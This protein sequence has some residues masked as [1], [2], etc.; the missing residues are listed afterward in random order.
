LLDLVQSTDVTHFARPGGHIG[1]MAGSKARG[2]IWPDLSRWLSERSDERRA[3]QRQAASASSAATL[4][5][6]P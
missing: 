4:R 6:L 2:Q 5:A 1:L 3:P